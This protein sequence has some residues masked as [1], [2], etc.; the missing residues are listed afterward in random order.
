[1]HCPISRR[2]ICLLQNAKQ[3]ETHWHRGQEI[4]VEAVCFQSLVWLR[5][6][7]AVAN[8]ASDFIAQEV[9]LRFHCGDQV[10]A[11]AQRPGR[12][13]SFGAHGLR[14]YREVP[15]LSPECLMESGS[16][17]EG[18]CFGIARHSVDHLKAVM[19]HELFVGDRLCGHR[20]HAAFR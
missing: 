11:T 20:R 2:Q 6:G 18:R 13:A 14:T 4:A 17:L 8:G 19:R 12:S 3:V 16:A 10:D 5:S 7:Y 1:M 9:G 15:G